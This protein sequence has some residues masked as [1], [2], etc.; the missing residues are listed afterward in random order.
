MDRP[1]PSEY[2]EYYGLYIG[3]VPEGEI[4]EILEHGIADTRELLADLPPEWETWRYE[5][6]KWSPRQVVDHVLDAER[7][8]GYRALSIARGD[9]A[10]L[11][12]MDQDLWAA[13]SNGAE[14][15]LASLLGELEHL[16]RSHIAMFAGFGDEV[17]G[18][19][20]IASGFE[21]T[22]RSFP[23]MIA[24][25]EIHHR[26]VLAERYLRPLRRGAVRQ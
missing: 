23:Y 11:P 10:P 1:Q 14:R 20:G 21:F 6:D 18:R 3:Q 9:P 17:W 19:R 7:V 13:G 5:A 22:V 8:F 2:E 26:R 15:P 25:H 12:S 4:L 16:R 24:G